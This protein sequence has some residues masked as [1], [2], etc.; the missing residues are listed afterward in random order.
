MHSTAHPITRAEKGTKTLR[1]HLSGLLRSGRGGPYTCSGEKFKLF[2]VSG[3]W[4]WGGSY[5]SFTDYSRGHSASQAAS[6]AY[7][8]TSSPRSRYSFSVH[9]PFGFVPGLHALFLSTNPPASTPK[10]SPAERSLD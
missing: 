4:F 6:C 9:G 10:S 3:S 2:P 8:R 7:A 1:G 5:T